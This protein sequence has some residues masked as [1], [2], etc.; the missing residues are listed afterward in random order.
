MPSSGGYP[1]RVGIGTASPSQV[2]EVAGQVYSSAGGFRFPDNTVQTT[3]AA[4]APTLTAGNGLNK[5]ANTFTLGGTLAYGTTIAQAGWDF[6]LTGGDVGIGTSSPS[7]RLEV[8]GQ[9]YSNTGGF[10]FPDNTVQT[11]ASTG[12][13][14]PYAGS[15]V[16][17][18]GPVFA[19]TNTG[20][21]GGTRASTQAGIGVEGIITGV[22]GIGLRGSAP[23]G[24]GVVGSLDGGS[25]QGVAGIKRTT[26]Q[27][28][29]V[30]LDAGVAGVSY[31]AAGVYGR[32]TTGFALH[33]EKKSSDVGPIAVFTNTNAAN[34]SIAV[35]I[36]TTGDQPALQAIHA[37]N[38]NN[39]AIRGVSSAANSS[40]VGVE[41]TVSSTV[42][43][44]NSA[45]VRGINNGS[46]SFG[47]GVYGSHAGSGT[48]VRGV[49]N[50]GFGVR[51]DGGAGSGVYGV[52][53]T[54]AGVQGTATSVGGRGVYG[55]AS[56]IGSRGLYGESDD[57]LGLYA[58]SG[59]SLAIQAVSDSDL[60][61]AASGY[62]AGAFIGAATYRTD[63]AVLMRN[64]GAGRGLTVVSQNGIAGYFKSG[65]GASNIVLH[66][67]VGQGGGRSTLQFSNFNYDSLASISAG[68]TV[69]GAPV[70]FIP[71]LDFSVTGIDRLSLFD[72]GG[73]MYGDWV[74]TGD[75]SVAGNLSKG[76]G[77]FKIDHPL[78][79][80][81]KYLYHSF[82]ESPDMMNVY[83]GNIMLDAQG[84][85]TVQL[86]DWFE[87]L[88]RDFRYQLTP[89]G[90]AFTPYVKARVA[91]NKFRIAGQPGAEVSW[92]VTGIRHDKYADAHR[93]P[94]E[95]VKR[96]AD[97]GYYL[98]PDAFGQPASRR[99]SKHRQ[100]R[101]DCQPKEATAVDAPASPSAAR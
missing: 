76:G 100:A 51:G 39:P 42:Q 68:V 6:S 8:A 32:S 74:A 5:I 14:L 64:N 45:G 27:S 72:D 47:A 31:A 30:P 2:L 87:T 34:D 71:R 13:S 17:N 49:S 81:N 101:M 18:I 28:V 12:L 62:H 90:A 7:Q 41:G 82:V 60:A 20:T 1:G 77:S 36:S 19:V 69:V 50:G 89:I 61:L 48:G 35:R 26:G 88:N 92:Q 29:P 25:G 57:G 73:A 10:R 99:L 65:E 43:G 24:Q 78:D 21:G 53:T 63:E 9:I 96:P 70:V 33:G 95:E 91:G 16:N 44:S 23:A 4:T 22:S 75:V 94:L 46:S 52:S 80:E 93:I 97:Q 54:G 56:G 98:H 11:T 86:P 84:E 85:A 83:N 55:S 79:P 3:A 37:A 67:T 59:T 66:N 15:A 38:S 58:H 40:G